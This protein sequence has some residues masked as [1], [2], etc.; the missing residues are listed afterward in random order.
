[1]KVY[2]VTHIH[3]PIFFQLALSIVAFVWHNFNQ[4]LTKAS[5]IWSQDFITDESV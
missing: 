3:E 1:M 2:D 5:T 4:L